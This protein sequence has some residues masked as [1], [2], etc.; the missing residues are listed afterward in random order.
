MLIQEKLAVAAALV[1]ACGFLV[2]QGVAS[3]RRKRNTKTCGGTCGCGKGS[4][5]IGKNAPLH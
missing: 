5:P 3:A 1:A 2:K 4:L